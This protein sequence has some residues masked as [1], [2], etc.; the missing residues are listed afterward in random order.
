MHSDDVRAAAAAC[1]GLLRGAVGRDWSVRAG[2]LDMTVAQVVAHV[3][4]SLLFYAA[5]LVGGP[6]LN[7]AL[8]VRVRPDRP[9]AALLGIVGTGAEVLA[10]TV[11]SCDDEVRGYHASGAADASGFAAMA[12]DELLVH[13]DDAARGLGLA[14]EPDARLAGHVVRRLFP[15][16]P[17][18]ERSWPTL[19]WAN[20]RAPLG[21]RPRLA[22]WRWHCA[23]LDEWDGTDPTR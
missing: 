5:D 20:G 13:T 14:F 16:A 8:E 15:W 17:H 21:G 3:G 9:P 11:E 4:E 2:D 10:S 19:R 7:D 1:T 22:D 18:D 12:C 23:P 6:V